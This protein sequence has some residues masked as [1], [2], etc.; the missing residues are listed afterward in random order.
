MQKS[1]PNK[2]QGFLSVISGALKVIQWFPFLG[3]WRPLIVLVSGIVSTLAAIKCESETKDETPLKTEPVIVPTPT[4]TPSPKPTRPPLPELKVERFVKAGEP[5]RVELCHV[6]N[7][8]DVSLF[9]DKWRLGYMG[10]GDPCMV[11][12]VTLNGKGQRKLIAVGSKNLR[13]EKDVVVQ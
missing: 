5:F 6:G 10:F 8:Y 11:L 9:A 2:F 13:V 1:K 4:A 7:Q 3:A 12:S